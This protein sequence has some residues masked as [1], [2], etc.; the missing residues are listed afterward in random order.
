MS[1]QRRIRPK[2]SKSGPIAGDATPKPVSK[3]Y[4]RM[5][6]SCILGG[7]FGIL[8]K[9]CFG[10]SENAQGVALQAIF[11]RKGMNVV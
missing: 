9:G 5:I 6:T 10:I 2:R 1:H 11:V 8:S 4:C 7:T 3:A